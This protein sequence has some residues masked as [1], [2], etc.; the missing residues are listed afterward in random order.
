ML[1]LENT[2]NGKHYFE[3]SQQNLTNFKWVDIITLAVVNQGSS[4]LGG[5]ILMLL[6]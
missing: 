5:K 4:C 3:G 2:K 1:K 6:S